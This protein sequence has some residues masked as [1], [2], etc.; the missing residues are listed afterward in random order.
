MPTTQGDLALLTDPVA[1]ALLTS[2][3]PAQLAYTWLDGSPRVVSMW[4][5]WNGE[6]FVLA[7]PPGAPKLKALAQHPRVALTIDRDGPPYQALLVRGTARVELVEGVAAE[8]AAAA[9][10]YLGEAE[11]RGWVEHLAGRLRRM[12]RIAVRPTWV[13]IF[14]FETR[15]PSALPA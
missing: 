10:R 9:R 8:Y 6:E 4:F 5:L 15:F 12:A 2:P 13:G 11:G 14:D 3:I 7:G 1:W